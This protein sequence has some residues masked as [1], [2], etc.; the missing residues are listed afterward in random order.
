MTGKTKLKTLTDEQKFSCLQ[1]CSGNYLTE[2]IPDD[3][4]EMTEEDQD[5]F[6]EEHS[7]EPLQ[8]YST[9]QVWDMIT[10]AAVACEH[11][12]RKELN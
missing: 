3:W 8:Y 9:I 5:I 7:W 6:L 4:E 10:S 2:S 1:S 11:L 12:L